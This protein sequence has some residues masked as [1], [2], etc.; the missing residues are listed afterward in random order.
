MERALRE[1]ILTVDKLTAITRVRTL[2]ELVSA[3]VAEPRFYTLLLA[4]FAAIALA[5]AVIGIYGVMAYAVSRRTHEIGIRLALGAEP[6]RILRMILNQGLILILTGAVIGLIGAMALTRMMSQLLFGVSA[7][8]PAVFAIIS[9]LLIAFALVACF[10]PARKA[11]Q[12]DPLAAL[13][14]E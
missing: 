7:T 5:L 2:E 13:R 9:L 4:L 10:L 1:R 8:D 3:S 14:H 11:T 6:G 12:I